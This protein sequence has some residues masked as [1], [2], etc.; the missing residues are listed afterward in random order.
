MGRTKKN[1]DSFEVYST[2]NSGKPKLVQVSDPLHMKILNELAKRPMSTTEISD[3]TKKAQS[4]LSIHLDQM[5]VQ[6]LISA[7]YDKN[8]SRRKIFT[9]SGKKIAFTKDAVPN[10]QVAVDKNIDLALTGKDKLY[11]YLADSMQVTLE[12][13]GLDI[14]PLMETFGSYV[15]NRL[16]NVIKATRVEDAIKELQEFYE[17][18]DIGAVSIYTFLPLTIIIKTEEEF[19]IKMDSFNSFNQGVFKTILSSIVG[20]KYVVTKSEIFGTG[21]NYFKFIIEPASSH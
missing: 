11:K 12:C 2:I 10:C 1:L 4:T 16:S 9:L 19:P 7:E 21:N 15:G 18:N 3:M 20:K 13:S 14:S 8:D 5:T 6:N 17:R